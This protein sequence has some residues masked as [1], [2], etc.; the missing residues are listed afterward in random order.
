MKTIIEL[1]SS[2]ETAIK[3]LEISSEVQEIA[4][5]KE[6]MTNSDYQGCIESQILNAIRYGI[7]LAQINK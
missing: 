1:M 5:N 4:D 7:E 6:E 3:M 2:K